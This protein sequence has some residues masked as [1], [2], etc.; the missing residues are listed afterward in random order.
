MPDVIIYDNGCNLA[1]HFLN[2]APTG[3]L[4]T[5][6][7]SDGFHWKNHVNCGATFNS[8]EY[9]YLK[10]NDYSNPRCYICIA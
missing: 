9:S 5:M 7:L 2:R 4:N 1:E 6:V 8:K 10:G 3:I